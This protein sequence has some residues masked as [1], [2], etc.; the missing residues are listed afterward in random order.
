MV[1][2]NL[3]I[4][5]FSSRYRSYERFKKTNYVW[6]VSQLRIC[7]PPPIRSG[8]FDIKDTQCAKKMKGVKFHITLYR[9]WAPKEPKRCPKNSTFFK[10]VQLCRVD[11]N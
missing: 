4:I 1:I 8:H 5:S 9:V 10:I 3:N 2:H 7:R 11:G 6:V